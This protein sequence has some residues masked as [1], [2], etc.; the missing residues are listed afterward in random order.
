MLAYNS[1][2]RSAD[3]LRIQLGW[4]R[5]FLKRLWQAIIRRKIINQAQV[6]EGLG[7]HAERLRTLARQVES[8]DPKNNEAQAARYYFG[9]LF[10]GFRRG[11][12]DRCNAALNY[13]YAILRAAVARDLVR[14]GFQTA[15]G[16]QHHSELNAFNL[17]DDLF[18]PFRP[19][20][21]LWVAQAQNF[22][23]PAEGDDKTA[24]EL[25]Q[26]ERAYLTQSLQLGCHINRRSQRLQHAIYLCVQSLTAAQRAKDY[27]KLQLPQLESPLVIRE[28]D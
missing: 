28:L 18:E 13:G 7:I 23:P 26:A 5:P 21:D 25:S 11:A 3:V 17:A 9:R 20:I 14:F 12:A 2:S 6:L 15:L 8:G 24:A 10:A 4:S 22:A 27:R 1:H 16:I 19:F